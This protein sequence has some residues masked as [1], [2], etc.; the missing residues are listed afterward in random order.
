VSGRTPS[1][2]AEEYQ[3]RSIDDSPRLMAQ[4]YSLRY[5]VYCL[6][7]QFLPAADYPEG[8]EIDEFDR[9]SVH[10]GV[11]DAHG[12][13]AATARVVD[14]TA[15]GPGLPLF[16][17]CRIFATET[18][19]LNPDN[20]VVEISRLS[21][22][23]SY[24]R[25]RRDGL[26]ERRDVRRDVFVTLLKAIYQ[27]TKRMEATHWLAATEK[28]LQ[29]LVAHYGF[30]FRMIGPDASYGGPVNPYLMDLAE[31]D[32]VIASHRIPE[33]DNFLVG[34][35]REFRPPADRASSDGVF[36]HPHGESPRVATQLALALS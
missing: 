22:T 12:D 25:R 31:F 16:R 20:H 7:R 9:H 24:W 4:S 14:V 1:L 33:L 27:A 8:L 28:S 13:L 34:L 3:A 35:E 10:V 30:P 5:Q 21:M 17:H 18:E 19:L 11:V 2:P 6:E 29:R 32:T 15:A 26:P 36:G 23:R